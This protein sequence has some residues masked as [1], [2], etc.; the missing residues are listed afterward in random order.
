MC[1][2]RSHRSFASL[3]FKS[4]RFGR[5]NSRIGVNRMGGANPFDLCNNLE[6]SNLRSVGLD[7]SKRK[8]VSTK[9]TRCV[10]TSPLKNVANCSHLTFKL[11][12]LCIQI[13]C[14]MVEFTCN[15][16]DLF[17][18]LLVAFRKMGH[19]RNMRNDHIYVVCH[20]L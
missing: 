10:H 5:G 14:G 17:D 11:P 8:I 9:P 4:D 16:G 2:K 1:C 3:T 19:F 12:Q 20:D 18:L 15:V 13:G 7:G 6:K